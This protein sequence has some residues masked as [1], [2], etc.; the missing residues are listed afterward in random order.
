MNEENVLF[1]QD[2]VDSVHKSRVSY[3][4]S[5]RGCCSGQEK[6]WNKPTVAAA[7]F[8][9]YEDGV[10]V[11]AGIKFK[12]NDLTRIVDSWCQVLQ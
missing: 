7:A 8:E 1:L 6:H 11:F 2:S 3:H 9:L 12:H 4:R 5:E 10:R